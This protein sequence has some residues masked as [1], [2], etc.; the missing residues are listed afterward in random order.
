MKLIGSLIIL[1]KYAKFHLAKYWFN[2]YNFNAFNDWLIFSR[3]MD[4]H[5]HLIAYINELLGIHSPLHDT[6]MNVMNTN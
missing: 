5:F 2:S 4:N 6:E 1:A 3:L